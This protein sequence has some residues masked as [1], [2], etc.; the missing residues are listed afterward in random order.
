VFDLAS[1]RRVAEIVAPAPGF[2]TSFSPDGRRLAIASLEGGGFVASARSGRHLYD[3]EGQGGAN[4]VDWS[5]NGK[6]IAAASPDARVRILDARTGRAR[7]TLSGHKGSVVAADWSA[8]SARLATGSSDGTAKVWAVDATEAREQ[9]SIS[10]QERG[11]GL[12]VAFS[13]DGRRLMTGD[14]GITV[15]K[16]WDV[17]LNGDAEWA[18]FAADR[19]QPGGVA[20][21]A[22]GNRVVSGNADGS[23]TVHDLRRP[24]LSIRLPAADDGHGPGYAVDTGPGGVVAVTAGDTARAWD[25]SRRKLIFSV[26]A[27]GGASDVAWSRDGSLLAVGGFDGGVTITGRTG[28]QRAALFEVGARRVTNLEFSPDRRLVAVATTPLERPEVGADR[29]TLWDWKRARK[30]R[31]LRTSAQGLAF[32]SDGRHLATAPATGPAQIW[33]LRS[34]RVVTRLEGHTGTVNDVAYAPDD[35]LLASASSDGTVRLWD[36]ESGRQET[37]LRGHDDI[38][39]DVDF[40][41]DGSKLVS[42]SPDGTVRVWALDLDDLIAIAKRNVTRE[43]TRTECLQYMHAP[44]K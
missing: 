29:V 34:G 27:S 20:F 19:R 10:A 11:G 8:D 12:W 41:P 33:D 7:F 37:V 17:S 22:D 1:E 44:C 30:V 32:S 28:R 14:Q 38:V 23:V 39:W 15:V 2:T 40:S 42:T 13:P 31:E 18:N 36:P 5:P 9:L 26:P 25:L 16:V 35:S 4:A 43:L 3:L 21:S 24:G 6:W